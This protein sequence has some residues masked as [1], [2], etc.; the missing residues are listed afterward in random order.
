MYHD[1]T[2]TTLQP[3]IVHHNEVDLFRLDSCAQRQQ[4]ID[5][6]DNNYH[7]MYKNASRAVATTLYHNI[8]SS[9]SDDYI[10]KRFIRLSYTAEAYLTLRSQFAMSLAVSSLFGYVLGGYFVYFIFVL[11]VCS[12]YKLCSIDYSIRLLV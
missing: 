10:R 6:Y 1:T 8:T 7:K 3:Q 11:C 2:L 5:T 12:W 9:V 4:F